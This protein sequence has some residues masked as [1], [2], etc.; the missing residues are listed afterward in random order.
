MDYTNKTTYNINNNIIIITKTKKLKK[1]GDD[2]KENEF[3]VF[4]KK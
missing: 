1:M 2:Y 3:D 4:Q